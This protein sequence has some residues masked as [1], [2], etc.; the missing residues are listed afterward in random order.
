MLRLL[1]LSKG[2]VFPESDYLLDKTD[3]VLDLIHVLTPAL[4]GRWLFCLVDPSIVFVDEI[5][6]MNVIPD[7]VDINLYAKGKKYDA[8]ATR[9]PGL[10]GQERTVRDDFEDLC[11][12]LHH[13]IDKSAM[14]QLFEAYRQSK[15]EV[16]S[17]IQ[18]LDKEVETPTISQKQI[19]Q[20][21]SFT[22][23]VYASS[24]L[25]AFLKGYGNRWDLYRVLCK[26][27]GMEIAYY[28][29]YKYARELLQNKNSYL[30]NQDVNK[31]IV[32]SVSA[33]ILCYVYALFSQSNNYR[34]LPVILSAIEN[35]CEESW[36][37]LSS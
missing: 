28:A 26:E 18:L 12:S 14:K 35:R 20:K 16:A 24:V 4:N 37:M 11:A 15:E 30:N 6:Q 19:Q 31:F 32:R 27:I 36:E 5:T 2:T 3:G 23:R 1:R 17:A 7:W 34:Q 22:K 21:I 13:P 25:D 9:F 8:L 10:S 33:P 29:M